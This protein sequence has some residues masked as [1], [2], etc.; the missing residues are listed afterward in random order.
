MV[1]MLYFLGLRLYYVVDWSFFFTSF[2]NIYYVEVYDRCSHIQ[3]LFDH[4]LFVITTVIIY[5]HNYF[6][7]FP[8]K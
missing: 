2:F 3:L 1:S 8:L 4:I 6:I 7:S 5:L